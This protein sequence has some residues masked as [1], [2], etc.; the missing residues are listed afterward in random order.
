V[1]LVFYFRI[2]VSLMSPSLLSIFFFLFFFSA[3]LLYACSGMN[4]KTYLYNLK[5][6][7]QIRQSYIQLFF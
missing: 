6:Y 1:I 7:F 2:I 3:K 5:D 4:S